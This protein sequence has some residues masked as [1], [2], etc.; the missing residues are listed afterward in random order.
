MLKIEKKKYNFTL[1]CDGIES[2]EDD[3]C[4][5]RRNV[6]G[7]KIIDKSIDHWVSDNPIFTLNNIQYLPI[8]WINIIN[9]VFWCYIVYIKKLFEY[10]IKCFAK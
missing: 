9:N 1:H 8:V 5:L 3:N 2:S 7:L 4:I 6:D 10:L